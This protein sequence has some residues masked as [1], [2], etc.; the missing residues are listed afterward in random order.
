MDWLSK[1]LISYI[2]YRK[3]SVTQSLMEATGEK[4]FGLEFK[5]EKKPSSREYGRADYVRTGE[6]LPS[7]YGEIITNSC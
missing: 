2:F 3:L 4:R 5:N 1:I 7:S 6:S